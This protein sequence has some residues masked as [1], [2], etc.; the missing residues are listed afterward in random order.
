VDLWYDGY[1]TNCDF[2][3][4]NDQDHDG[5]SSSEHTALGTD[6]NDLDPEINTEGIETHDGEDAAGDIDWILDQSTEVMIIGSG[7]TIRRGSRGLLDADFSR[8]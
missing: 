2:A 3:N 4:D 5:Y 7:T 8:R 1:D 6:C